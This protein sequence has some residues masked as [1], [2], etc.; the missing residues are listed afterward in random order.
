MA[1]AAEGLTPG[2]ID[3]LVGLVP[4]VEI[5]IA[6]VV[7]NVFGLLKPIFLQDGDPEA[8]PT[9]V[10]S[11]LDDCLDPRLLQLHTKIYRTEH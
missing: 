10:S 5:P 2:L 6:I 9:A 7:S 8:T 4:A 3:E 11:G 1:G